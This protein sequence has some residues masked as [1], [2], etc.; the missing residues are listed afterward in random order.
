MANRHLLSNRRQELLFR[1]PETERLA[2]LVEGFTLADVNLQ[3][4]EQAV[5]DIAGALFER[6][7]ADVARIEGGELAGLLAEV[8]TS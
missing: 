6:R 7:F 1:F 5:R 3:A 8:R 2:A 4:N